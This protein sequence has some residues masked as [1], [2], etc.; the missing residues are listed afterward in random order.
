MVTSVVDDDYDGG[1]TGIGIHQKRKRPTLLSYLSEHKH[2]HF[3]LYCI[4]D[5]CSCGIVVVE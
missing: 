5:A 3:K 2:L 4:N 1:G